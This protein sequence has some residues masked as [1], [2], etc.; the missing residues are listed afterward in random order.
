[1]TSIRPLEASGGVDGPHDQQPWLSAQEGTLGYNTT[2]IPFFMH[3]WQALLRRRLLVAIILISSL[4]VAGLVTLLTPPRYTAQS[5]VEISREQKNITKVE[6]LEGKTGVNDSEFYETQY[7]LL[8]SESL[9]ERVVRA[10]KLDQN[11]DF[12]MSQGVDIE[13]IKPDALS[14]MNS[15]GTKRHELAVEILLDN[16]EINPLRKSRL[17]EVRYTSRSAELSAKLVNT[18]T[19]EFIGATMDRQ[20]SSSA[21]AR[22]FLEGRLAQ[23]RRLIDDA[24]RDIVKYVNRNGIVVL[25]TAR[26]AEGKTFSNRT[27]AATD[28]EA[29]NDALA[30]ARAARIEAEAKARSSATDSTIDALDNQTVSQLR[31]SR[32]ELDAQY[33]KLISQFEPG[34]PPAKAVKDQRDRIDSAIASEISRISRAKR[35]AYEQAV[36]QERKLQAK[37]DQLIAELSRQREASIQQS[38]IQRDVDTNRQLYDALLQRYKEIGVAG[39]VG[40]SNIAIVDPAKVPSNPSSPNLVLNLLI[41]LLGG[42]LASFAAVFAIEQVDEGIRSPDDVRQ[43]LNLALLGNIPLTTADPVVLLADSKSDIS[44]AYFS[45]RST[46]A[47]STNNG[48]P[49]TFAVTSTRPAEGKSTSAFSLASIIAKT[50]KKVLLIDGDMRSP[51]LHGFVELKNERGLSNLLAG[52]DVE[53]TMSHRV[54]ENLWLLPAGPIPP[55]PAEL[56]SSDRFKEILNDFSATFDHVIIDLPPVLGLADSVLM[57]RAVSGVVYIVKAESTPRRA[58]QASIQR[59]QVSGVHVFGVVITQV[60]YT[61]HNMGYGYGYGYGYAYGYGQKPESTELS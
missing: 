14:T 5:L 7:A 11:A 52:S 54:A 27:L 44:E 46:L 33:A 12:F 24:E 59:L 53:A 4:V 47:F 61:K 16:I 32:A 19:R 18:W 25:D 34:Y 41:A 37:V 51:S 2:A 45:T 23:L 29:L 31:A 17:V 50:N 49:K 20:F 60:D 40:A 13:D 57:G 35:I 22:T 28:L 55:S 15:R 38:I 8:K 9:A 36:D 26:D 3:A 48:L 42:A 56:L 6:G 43:R 1:M 58:I 10:L 21:D 30:K 39:S